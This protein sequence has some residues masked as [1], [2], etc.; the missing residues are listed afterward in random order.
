MRVEAIQLLAE[1]GQPDSI[2]VLVKIVKTEPETSFKDLYDPLKSA[3]CYRYDEY[4]FSKNRLKRDF[5]SAIHEALLDLS[6]VEEATIRKRA[7]VLLWHF[8]TDGLSHYPGGEP[9]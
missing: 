6:Q 5:K 9:Y 1:L 2:D 4:A 7:E 8:R 3:L